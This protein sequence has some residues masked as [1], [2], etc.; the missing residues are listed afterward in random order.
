MSVLTIAELKQHVE[1]DLADTAL[2]RVI[3]AVEAD[4]EA[5]AG[6]A[7]AVIDVRDYARGDGFVFLSQPAGSITSVT[8]FYGGVLTAL[9]ASDYTIW[10][11]GLMLERNTTGAHP[12]SYWQGRVTVTFTPTDQST[13]RK[14]ATIDLCKLELQYNG[15]ISESA[16]GYN[17]TVGDFESNRRRIL[18]RLRS[19]I[20]IV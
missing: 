7:T 2:Q 9:D 3:D 11:D 16:G 17:L 6:S 4:V 8:E 14:M 1:T 20:G 5:F 13:R 12:A 15:T 18:S 10:N 19:G